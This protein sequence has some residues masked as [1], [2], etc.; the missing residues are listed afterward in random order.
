MNRLC[1]DFGADSSTARLDPDRVAGWF[2]F[3]WGKASPQTFNVR[4]AAWR[5]ACA[6]WREQQWLGG[7]PLVRLVARSVPRDES[8]A[9]T[10]AQVDAV[11]GLDAALRER[12]LWQ[13]LYE[14]AARAE[15]VLML[16]VPDL[17]TANRR[18]VVIRKGGARDVVVWQTGTARLLPRMLAGH[19]AGPLFLSDRK[20]K[21]SVALADVDLGT[22]RARLSYRRAAE[23]FDE[24]TA[25]VAGGPFT[26]HQLRHSALTHAAEDGASTPMLMKMSGHVSVRS[27]GKYV[28]PSAEALARWCA[29]TDPAARLRR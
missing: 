3:V 6:Y 17:D 13:M 20:A 10:R 4:L 22:G 9:L 16:N 24:A 15:E 26:L 1:K 5:A 21:P 29:E 8:R 7:D 28:R 25:A 23:L 18:A 14:T 12:V 19:H 27:L 11:L 2:T